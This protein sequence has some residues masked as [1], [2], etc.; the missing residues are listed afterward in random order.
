M[1]KVL[2]I[3]G[4]TAVGKTDLSIKLA[5]KFAGE[6]IS[7]DSMQVYRGLDIGTAK[8]TKEEMDGVKHHLIDIR[9]IDERFSVADFVQRA[10]KDIQTIIKSGNLPIIVGGTG[11]YLQALLSGLELGGDEYENNQLRQQLLSDAQNDGY[12]KLHH[13]LAEVDPDAAVGIPANNVRRVVRALEVYIKTGHRFSDQH[14]TGNKYDAFVI[15][16]TT[17]RELLYQRIN[18]RVDQMIA[19]G[20]VNEAK[21]LFDQGG[22]GFQSGKGIG[23]RELFPYFEHQVSLDE[24]IDTI[25]KDSR[26]YAKR[27]LTWFRNKTEPKPNWYNLVEHPEAIKR[28]NED[29]T[30][31][32]ANAK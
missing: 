24:A 10:S 29:V 17:D 23:Y 26:H 25:K 2:A 21:A 3:V 14:N 8:V 32:L 20:L 19:T 11:F 16:L 22:Q 13:R 31:W 30:K 9:N 18:Q 7:G 5:Q 6:I 15:G 12:E 4:P 27:Q 28:I 1:T